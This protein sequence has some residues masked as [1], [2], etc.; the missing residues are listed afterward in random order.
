MKSLNIISPWPKQK[1]GIADYAEQISQYIPFHHNVITESINC[2]NESEYIRILHPNDL[3]AQKSLVNG[4]NLFHIGNNPD[5]IYEIPLFLK[6]NGNVVLHDISLHYL[7]ELTNN[8]I[9][10][11]FSY[12]L[13]KEHPE[14]ADKILEHWRVTGKKTS[15]DYQELNIISW[16][17]PAHNIIVHSEFAA[18]IV[19][20]YL[21]RNKIHVIPHFAYQF[22]MNI[23]KIL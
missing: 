6:H 7:S 19:K 8:I 11:F 12:F 23:K 18:E 20:G 4:T 16:L 2:N 15:I 1:N 5:H 17:K 10:D 21:P 3:D 13:K 14:I 22:N 9:P